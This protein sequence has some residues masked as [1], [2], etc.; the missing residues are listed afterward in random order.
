MIVVDKIRYDEITKKSVIYP[1]YDLMPIIS[2]IPYAPEDTILD[3]DDFSNL[4][5]VDYWGNIFEKQQIIQCVDFF[6]LTKSFLNYEQYKRIIEIYPMNCAQKFKENPFFLLSLDFSDNNINFN[7]IDRNVNIKTFNQRLIEIKEAIK[8]VLNCSADHG[9]TWLSYQTLESR[10]L[11]LLKKN[12][13]ELDRGNV[14]TYLNYWHKEFFFKTDDFNMS[15][16]ITTPELYKTEKFIYQT[17]KKYLKVNSPYHNFNYTYAENLSQKQNDAIKNLITHNGRFAILTGGPGTGKTTILKEL[18]TQFRDNYPDKPIQIISPTGR[19]AKR[20]KEVMNDVEVEVSTM[21][22]FLNIDVDNHIT[23]ITEQTYLKTKNIRLLIIEESSMADLPIFKM[24][25]DAVDI[26]NTK[27]ILVG[28]TNQL[29]SVGAGDLLRDLIQMGVY[30]EKLTE[31]FRFVGTIA[32]N[33]EKINNQQ[34]DLICDDTFEILTV[35]ENEILNYVSNIDADCFITPYKRED[36]IASTPIINRIIQNKRMSSAE[37]CNNSQFRVGDTVIF[38]HTRYYKGKNVNN[39]YFNGE[40][41]KITGYEKRNNEYTV[42][43]DNDRT[44]T[45]TH[46]EDMDLGYAITIHKSQGS[47]YNHVCILLPS[48]SEF[49][50]KKMFYT[51]VTRAKQKVT[52]I[53][54]PGI[55]E[56]VI[57]NTSD[58]NRNTILNELIAGNIA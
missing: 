35:N 26:F 15:T 31:S 25:L 32:K 53:T 40:I 39:S 13:H 20:V 33:A 36:V 52:I 7:A 22:K 29:P 43:I 37:R 14:A 2:D 27:I 10:V 6:H 56:K 19:A 9:N 44:V 24:I 30:V 42:A 16:L 3:Y 55:L 11:R 18:V 47:E 4:R 58:L 48:Y 51:A 5:A 8:Y 21:H 50:S 41:G 17:V 38:T 23:D 57:G 49:I 28:D 45:T 46:P 34:T 12:G 54:L 1:K